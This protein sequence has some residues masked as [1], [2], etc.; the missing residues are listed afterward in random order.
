MAGALEVWPWTFGF[1]TAWLINKSAG[2][3]HF[4]LGA[5]AGYIPKKLSALLITEFRPVASIC[6]KL[7][8]FPQI[9][10]ILLDHLTEDFELID[11][12]HEGF[13]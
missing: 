10:D 9:I 8:I 6:P 7:M 11:D 1:R 3:P 4:W 13:R 2:P 5:I 12:A